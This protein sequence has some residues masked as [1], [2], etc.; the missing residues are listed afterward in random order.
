[1]QAVSHERVTLLQRMSSDLRLSGGCCIADWFGTLADTA[2]CGRFQAHAAHACSRSRWSPAKRFGVHAGA[3]AASL[4]MAAEALAA[5]LA[6]LLRMYVRHACGIRLRAA[7]DC[8][9]SCMV[10]FLGNGRTGALLLSCGRQRRCRR[11]CHARWSSPHAEHAS[12]AGTVERGTSKSH[13]PCC[14]SG[15]S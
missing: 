9:A 14:T 15:I 11:T 10:C 13:M 6:A 5:Q 8:M 7:A 2:A 12:L 4:S 1:M 3:L